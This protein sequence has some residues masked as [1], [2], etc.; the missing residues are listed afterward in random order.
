MYIPET[1][2]LSHKHVCTFRFSQVSELV[3][4]ELTPLH[5]MWANTFMIQYNVGGHNM[6]TYI[7][8][9]P[10]RFIRCESSS[11]TAIDT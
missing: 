10:E 1:I 7:P 4:D 3:S 8:W 5:D 11:Y 2:L 9:I 6:G